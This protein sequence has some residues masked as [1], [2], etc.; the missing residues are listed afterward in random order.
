MHFE[1]LKKL[2]RSETEYAILLSVM[3]RTLLKNNGQATESEIKQELQN[4]DSRYNSYILDGVLESLMKNHSPAIR[5]DEKSQCYVLG[6]YD[7]LSTAKKIALVIFCNQRIENPVLSIKEI[8]VDEII[9]Q[10]KQWLNSEAGIKQRQVIV[11]EKIEV[12]ELMEKLSKMDKKDPEFTD[13]VLYGL[14]PY[15]DTKFAKRVSTFPTFMNIKP[16]FKNYNYSDDDWNIIANMIFSLAKKCEMYPEKLRQWIEEFTA[17]EIYSRNLQCGSITP[18]LFCINDSFP[19]INNRIIRTYNEFSDDQGWGDSMSQKLVNYFDNIPKCQKLM[20]FLGIEEMDHEVFD[21]FCWRY[22]SIKDKD[23]ETDDDTDETYYEVTSKKPKEIDLKEFVNSLDLEKASKLEHYRLRSPDKIRI[24]ELL[25]LCQKCEWQLPNFQRYFDWKKTDIRD[26]LDSVFKN[27]YIGSLLLWEADIDPQLKLIPILGVRSPNDDIQTKMIILDG[28]QRITSL[29]YAIKGTPS[30]TK[31]IKKPIYFYIDFGR[32]LQGYENGNIIMREQKLTWNESLKSLWFPFYELENYTKWTHDFS[33]TIIDEKNYNKVTEIRRILDEKLKHFISEFEIPYIV[34]PSSIELPQ[35]ADIFEKINTKGK[36]LSVFD[37]LIATLS[38]YD[39]D[40]RRLWDDVIKKYPVFKTYNSEDKLPIYILQSIALYYHDLSLCGKEDLLKM[41]STIVEPKNLIFDEVWDE[42]AEWVSKA[43]FKLEN[44]NDGFGVRGKK[45][46]SYMPA[47]PILAA[48]LRNVDDRKNKNV[49][50]SKIKRWYWS[51]IFSEMYSSGVDSQLTADYRGMAGWK[52]E[53]GKTVQ[54]WFD[55]DTR[56]LKSVENFSR[57][58][59][60]TINLKDVKNGAIFKGILS[61]VALEG[62]QD[63]DT[64]QHSINDSSDRHHIFPK[65]QFSKQS[66]NVNSIL[67]ITWLSEDTN[68][69]IIR[70][71]KPSVYTSK[72]LEKNH[73]NDQEKFQKEIL[74]RHFINKNAFEYMLNDDFDNFIKE[75]EKEILRKIAEVVGIPSNEM[76]SSTLIKPD[77]PFSNESAILKTI[78]EC[79]GYICWIDKYFDRKGLE[80]LST[81]LQQDGKIKSIKILTAKS[82][83]TL[84]KTERLRDAFKKFRDEMKHRGIISELRIFSDSK[85][86]KGIHDRWLITKGTAYSVPS[87][88][89]IMRG[90]SSVITRDVE[91]PNFEEWWENSLDVFEEWHKIHESRQSPDDKL[92]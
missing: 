63:F 75:R 55:D 58:L 80:W 90:Q 27:F 33:E 57:G 3:I 71:K 65:Q 43:I 10:F 59:L 50:H 11:N 23:Q 38:K 79:Q 21:L 6:D 5:F 2:I 84:E 85:T 12:K 20:D 1:E 16:F 49:C 89:T 52:D 54:G 45:S 47:I 69:K 7:L 44:H 91:R 61:L 88:D 92:D 24:R 70:A 17:N 22:Y 72:F 62:A 4:E 64:G 40:L 36:N 66:S 32:Y 68:R 41:Y 87:T 30:E 14:L 37:I 74:D 82:R 29:Y 60:N 73:N 26:L 28:Q 76:P 42:M 48:L 9:L 35:V 56:I 25:Q 46:L 34:L 15:Y 51:S 18:I 67:N 81:A 31:T 83:P 8:N 78:Q 13:L 53:S 86:A 19:I 77:T 39:I